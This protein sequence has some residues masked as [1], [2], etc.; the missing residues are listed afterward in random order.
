MTQPGLGLTERVTLAVWT[1]IGSTRLHGAGG[2]G[3]DGH[4]LPRQVARHLA[5]N[6][7]SSLFSTAV[8]EVR[9]GR[10]C[11]WPPDRNL[12]RD[13]SQLA[14]GA[15]KPFDG[16]INHAA[17]L[18]PGMVN[19]GDAAAPL[20]GA[21]Q[22]QTL[23]LAMSEE[24][25]ACRRAAV[26]EDGALND[27]STLVPPVRGVRFAKRTAELGD[28]AE[29]GLPDGMRAHSHELYAAQWLD[30]GNAL[31]RTTLQPGVPLPE[32]SLSAMGAAAVALQLA[33]EHGMRH[34]GY[35]NRL[36]ANGDGD[37]AFYQGDGC[38]RCL[39][40]AAS[41]TLDPAHSLVRAN[42]AGTSLKIN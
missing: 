4:E 40:H 21:S 27:V 23:M 36:G 37:R 20:S 26:H 6:E 39:P 35:Y 24:L 17:Q 13:V 31:R 28:D 12:P 22:Q 34:P 5:T 30:G 10:P 9:A 38:L 25:A 3:R 18:A 16:T 33:L 29:L 1:A 41:R 11:A 7:H 8:H 32:D 14:A 42:S 19:L 2:R 15:F